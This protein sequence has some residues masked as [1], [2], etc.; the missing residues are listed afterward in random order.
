MT[1]P[2]LVTVAVL[3]AL[4]VASKLPPLLYWYTVDDT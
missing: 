4:V 2:V 1:T 3:I